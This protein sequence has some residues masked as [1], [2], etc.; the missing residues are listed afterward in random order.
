LKPVVRGDLQA[1]ARSPGSSSSS[2]GSG[3]GGGR[4]ASVD[5][6]HTGES[7]GQKDAVAAGKSALAGRVV[8]LVVSTDTD[9]QVCR[10]VCIEGG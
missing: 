4:S 2:G 7:K 9:T 8:L 1:A 3:G 6:A 10:T 5:G